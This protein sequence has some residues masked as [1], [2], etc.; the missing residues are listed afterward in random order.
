MLR[1]G[2]GLEIEQIIE[3]RNDAIGGLMIGKRGEIAQIRGPDDGGDQFAAAAPDFSGKHPRPGLV[4]KI[5]AK[6]IFGD[7]FLTIHVGDH[8]DGLAQIAEIGNLTI[9]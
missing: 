7:L 9:G 5:G 4:P 1:N 8:S 6:H 3:R 2:P